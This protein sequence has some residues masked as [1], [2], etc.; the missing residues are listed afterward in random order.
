LEHLFVVQRDCDPSP[1]DYFPQL[2]I[3][4]KDA[5][6]YNCV[7]FDEKTVQLL[8]GTSGVFVIYFSVDVPQ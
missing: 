4:I 3:F 2:F 7:D 1:A 6:L 5:L 8:S